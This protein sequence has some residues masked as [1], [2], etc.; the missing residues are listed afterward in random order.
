MSRDLVG[1]ALVGIGTWAALSAGMIGLMLATTTVV[2]GA[3][4]T[5]I[6]REP[7]SGSLSFSCKAA[8]RDE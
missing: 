5:L 2:K 1:A 8:G 3:V 4:S 6:E 7:E